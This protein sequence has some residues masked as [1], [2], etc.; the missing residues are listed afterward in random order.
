MIDETH[1]RAR[2]SWV[3]FGQRPPGIPAAEPAAWRVQPARGGPDESPRGGVAIGDMILDLR[4]A[5]GRRPVLRRRGARRRGGLGRH[6]EPA[7]GARRRAAP[8]IAAAGLSRCSTPT[9]PGA[10]RPS[11]SPIACCIAPPIAGCICRR[12]SATSPISSPASITPRMADAVATRTTRS[13]RIT[14]M[15]RSPITAA[16]RRCAN[17][18]FR[19]AARTDSANCRTRTRRLTARA[20]ISTTSWNSR[21]G[22]AR[23]TRR[24]S[25]SRSGRPAT[26]SSASA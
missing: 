19:C 9:D 21:C 5:L 4:A 22:S 15:S 11:R 10:P 25:R 6:V 1:D 26:T 13:L 23:A 2:R 17:R 24:A 20:A 16:P 3:G 12:R 18:T 7:D 8:R 14:N